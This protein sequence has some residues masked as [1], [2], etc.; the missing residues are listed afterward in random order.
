MAQS[1]SNDALWEKLLE[2][3]RKLDK[4]AIAQETQGSIRENSEAIPDLEQMK[5]ELIIEIKGQAYLLGKHNDSHFGANMQNIKLLNENILKVVKLIAC[6]Q[7]R[8]L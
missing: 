4:L 2:I 3:E 5:K 8:L 6:I 7:K 1:V